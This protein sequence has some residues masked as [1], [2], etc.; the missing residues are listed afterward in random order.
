MKNI[1]VT[2]GAGYIGSHIIEILI[3]ENFNI[4]IVDNLTTGHKKLINQKA[5]FFN[6][7]IINT[8]KLNGI[9]LKNK[10]DSIIHLAASLVIG[11]G[12][13]H[14]KKYYLNNVVGTHNLIKACQNSHVRNF[15]FSSTAAVYSDKINIVDEKS[16]IKPKSVYGKTKYKAEKIIIKSF[17]KSEV[18]FAILRYF[19]VAGA[20][21]SGQIGL[22]SKSDHLFKNISSEAI[23]KV[24]KINIYGNDYKTKDK[25][26]IRDF[27]HV[28]DLAEIHLKVLVKI[29]RLNRSIILNCGYNKKTSV[30]DVVNEFRKQVKKKFSIKFQKRRAG[31]ME[32]VIANNLKL[33]KFIK[34]KP[35]YGSL[36][37]IVKSCIKWEKK[38][39]KNY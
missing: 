37:Q 1:L 13:K 6:C 2:G 15:I 33:K 34:W 21:S 19:N 5:K 26:A 31:D 30:L 23:K 14:P 10:I 36:K 27:I 32:M 4:F 38:I 11:E 9:I 22:I 3:K 7:D 35:K 17:E 39:N 18:N 29:S 28:S 8:K 20:S 25:T 12:E 24:P 16:K